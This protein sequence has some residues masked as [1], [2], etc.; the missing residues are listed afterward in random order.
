MKRAATGS[1]ASVPVGALKI[2]KRNPISAVIT[3]TNG[4]KV[5]VNEIITVL[6]CPL[7]PVT[8]QRLSG[9]T[10]LKCSSS[11]PLRARAVKVTVSGLPGQ[12]AS[13]NAKVTAKKGAKKGT[14]SLTMKPKSVLL[15]GKFVYKHVA[16][17]ARKGEKLLAVR[18][19]TL[20]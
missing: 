17:T 11:M 13:G 12:S 18:V 6:K 8:C 10:Q 2:G 4:K 20:G 9:G 15:P 16:T 1:T 3:L 19:L 14:Y 5:T 7:P